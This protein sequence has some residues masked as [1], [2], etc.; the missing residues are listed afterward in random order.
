MPDA[1]GRSDLGLWVL[2]GMTRKQMTRPARQ[3]ICLQSA[4][5]TCGCF[6][7]CPTPV[8]DKFKGPGGDNTFHVPGLALSEIYHVPT[9]VK[10]EIWP[11]GSLPAVTETDG[12]QPWIMSEVLSEETLGAILKSLRAGTVVDLAAG[13]GW[14]ASCIFLV[15]RGPDFL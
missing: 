6:C 3:E 12:E 14:G 1:P 4:N 7:A 11:N 15:F 8:Q 2:P 9:A 10:K 13:H 5:V